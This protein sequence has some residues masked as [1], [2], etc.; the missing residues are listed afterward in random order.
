MVVIL[1]KKLKE[2]IEREVRKQ[3]IEW[4]K[5]MWKEVHAVLHGDKTKSREGRDETSPVLPIS[6]QTKSKDEINFQNKAIS[7]TWEDD[8]DGNYIPELECDESED[9]GLRKIREHEECTDLTAEEEDYLLEQGR[10][11]DYEEKGK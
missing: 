9:E 8:G 10:E 11:R 6:Q 3:M 5:V 1:D 2:E 7:F 4:D